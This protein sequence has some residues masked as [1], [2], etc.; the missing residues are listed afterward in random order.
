MKP[1]LIAIE[2]LGLGPWLGASYI[3]TE[4]IPQVQDLVDVQVY[5]WATPNKVF[6]TDRHLIFAAHSFGA[7]WLCGNGNLIP[8]GSK[9]IT[10]DPR[11]T[12]FDSFSSTPGFGWLN[13]YQRNIFW[14]PGCAVSG[15]DNIGPVTGYNH[16]QMPGYPPIAKQIRTWASLT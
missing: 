9:V 3:Q 13:F 15:A 16:T 12:G 7:A 4:L 5:S 1:L 10:I 2:G 8:P 14:F 11:W 6:P